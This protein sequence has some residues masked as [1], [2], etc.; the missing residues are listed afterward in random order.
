MSMV[1]VKYRGSLAA[2]NGIAEETLEAANVEG[3]Q[4]PPYDAVRE[5]MKEYRQKD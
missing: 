1:Q 3:V 4:L 2:I 5:E